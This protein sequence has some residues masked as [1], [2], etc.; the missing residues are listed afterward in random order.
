M[1]LVS[2]AGLLLL[3][4][5]EV[6]GA[7]QTQLLLGL[8]VLALQSQHDLLGSLG[9]LRQQ[10]QQHTTRQHQT[11]NHQPRQS[12]DMTPQTLSTHPQPSN[13]KQKQTNIVVEHQGDGTVAQPA[14]SK[15]LNQPTHGT[16]SN[17]NSLSILN[18]QTTKPLPSPLHTPNKQ[19]TML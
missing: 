14:T 11:F 2:A 17:D 7:L 16:N 19:E 12:K 3:T 1:R 13:N 15:P 4:Q 10:K 6:L 9:L 18:T 5:L 8:A